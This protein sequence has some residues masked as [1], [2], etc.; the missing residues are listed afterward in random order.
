MFSTLLLFALGATSVVNAQMSHTIIVGSEGQRVSLIA[1]YNLH[2]DICLSAPSI[3]APFP[4]DEGNC[5]LTSRPTPLIRA[6]S[7]SQLQLGLVF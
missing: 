3:D 4:M 1:L 6:L 2:N 7:I 5:R